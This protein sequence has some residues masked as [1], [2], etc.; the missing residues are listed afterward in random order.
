MNPSL[1]EYARPVVV[2]AMTANSDDHHVLTLR[3]F[4]NHLFQQN[5]MTKQRMEKW[6]DSMPAN[7]DHYHVLTLG[8]LSKIT[9]AR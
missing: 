8:C 3:R 5:G 4:S 6:N 1:D 7:S 2:A 9:L